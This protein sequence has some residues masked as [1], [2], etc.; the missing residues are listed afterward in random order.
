MKIRFTKKLIIISLIIILVIILFLII[1]ASSEKNGHEL[2]TVERGDIREE[3]DETG[4]VKKGEEI[5]LSFKSAGR[6]EKFYFTKGAVVS[7][8]DI[9]AK[10]DSASIAYQ[11]QQ[12]RANLDLAEA[13]L[14]KLLAGA[15]AEEIQVAQTTVTNAQNTLANEQ[16]DLNNAQAD[17]DEDLAQAY[18]DGYNTMN[19]AYL[20]LDNAA[21]FINSL[22]ATYFIANDQDSIEIQSILNNINIGLDGMEDYLDMLDQVLVYG[23][24][25]V[26]LDFFELEL[27]E[28]KDGISRIKNI[29]EKPLWRG[30]IS[31]TDKTSLD[32]NRSN[33]ITSFSNV[34]DAQQSIAS[35]KITNQTNIDTAENAVST[36]QNSLQSAQDNS[37]LV[38]ADPRSEDVQ[39][40]QAKVDSAK[41]SVNQLAQ[42]VADTNLRSPTDGEIVDIHKFEGEV[43]A[44]TTP[45]V[46]ILPT[47]DLNIEVDIYEED[48]VDVE[49][50]DK[51]EISLVAFPDQEFNGQVIF[52]DPAEKLVESVVYYEVKV[53]F[54]T[55]PEK[56]KPGMTADIVII[57]DERIDVISV[58][59]D[60]IVNGM[61][62]VYK[63]KKINEREVVLGLEGSD[64]MIEII[65][66]LEQGEQVIIE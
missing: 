57:T 8:N 28:A 29:T 54:N 22:R 56:I 53:S 2:F 26:A 6:I 31:S 44:A 65:S 45:V 4:M 52:I 5:D 38:T 3:I 60:A 59:D 10:I 7:K 55:I 46:T 32:T 34:V 17:A 15:S 25:D 58:I 61:V 43:V 41:A 16:E 40:Y 21:I 20:N 14:D 51:V 9:I 66:G 35:T 36:A 63:N 30:Q 42:G 64:G 18:E 27:S 47:Q 1:N 50:G 39:L 12:A 33:V 37:A 49:I 24:V 19:D 11:L 23:D 13:E 48:I 62:K